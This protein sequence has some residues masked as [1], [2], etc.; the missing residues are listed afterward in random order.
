MSNLMKVVNKVI[1]GVDENNPVGVVRIEEQ[2]V[3]GTVARIKEVLT[4]LYKADMDIISNQ[5][6]HAEISSVGRQLSCTNAI[7]YFSKRR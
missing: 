7:I 3:T 6:L 2:S 1:E 5:I 4:L